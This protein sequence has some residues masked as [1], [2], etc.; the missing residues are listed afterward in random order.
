MHQLLSILIGPRAG[1]GSQTK[2]AQSV[3]G[4]FSSSRRGPTDKR[5]PGSF[6]DTTEQLEFRKESRSLPDDTAE[7]ITETMVRYKLVIH[8]VLG[9]GHR[10]VKCY[11]VLTTITPLIIKRICLSRLYQA[12]TYGR[13]HAEKREELRPR[14]AGKPVPEPEFMPPVDVLLRVH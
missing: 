7:G 12:I 6:P 13:E 1:G 9:G 11:L 5:R 3:N 2:L 8:H 14:T 4:L 10:F